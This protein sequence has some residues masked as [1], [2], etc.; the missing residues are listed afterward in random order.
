MYEHLRNEFLQDLSCMYSRADLN[1]IISV[2]DKVAQGYDVTE[3]CTALVV[4]ENSFPKIAEIYLQSKLLEGKAET[5]CKLYRNRLKI[6]FEHVQ[7][8]PEDVT[9]NDIRYFLSMYQ[10]Q[11]NISNVTLDKFRQIIDGFYDWCVNEDY[12]TKNPC[13]NI[14]EIKFEQKPVKALTRMELE[15]LRR[16]CKDKRELA[17]VDVLYS[18]GCRVSELVN[19]KKSDIN[20]DDKSIHIVGKGKKHNTCYFNTNAQLS[21]TAYLDTRRDSNDYLFVNS[22]GAHD[23]LSAKAIQNIFRDLRKRTNLVVTPHVMRHTTATIALQSGMPLTQVQKML[24][25]SK[26][27]TTLRYAEISQ[28]DVKTSH[29]KYVV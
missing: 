3:K 12:L 9:T 28:Q 22:K 24:N 17:I 29:L 2:L 10:R 25:H 20:P 4:Y 13:R 7:K 15:L 5:T 26:P 11:T 6:F 23:K 14:T 1:K 19:M 8:V 16:A 18:T 21:L 27:D